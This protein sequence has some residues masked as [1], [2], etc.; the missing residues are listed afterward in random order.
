VSERTGLGLVELELLAVLRALSPGKGTQ[1]FGQGTRTEP[2]ADDPRSSYEVL[3]AVERQIGLAPRYAYEVLCDMARPWTVPLRLVDFHGDYGGRDTELRPADPR[4]TAARLSRVGELVLQAERGEM[5][6]LPIGLING[7]VHAEGTRPPFSPQR[8]IDAIRHVFEEPAI[9]DAAVTELVGPP[10]FPTG[11]SVSGDLAALAAGK[12]VELR[13]GATL[14]IDDAHRRV[15]IEHLPP[16]IGPGF[17]ATSIANRRVRRDWAEKF[18]DLDRSAQLALDQLENLSTADHDQ[19]VCT[20]T[21]GVPVEELR[22]QLRGV[23]G[24]TATM[25]VQLPAPIS[26]LVRRFVRAHQSEHLAASLRELEVAIDG[27]K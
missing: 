12:A 24:V 18:P 19:V 21:A 27:Q 23:Y 16:R 6:P 9:D 22:D 5:A 20:A 8:V 11:C 1:L 17:L 10:Q 3:A 4:Y 25:S 15:V 13:L 14:S 2:S 26:H 7:N